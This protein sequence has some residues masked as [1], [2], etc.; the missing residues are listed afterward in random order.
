MSD[1]DGMMR[2]V[3][4]A[5]GIVVLLSTM[6]GSSVLVDNRYAKAVDVQN[7][8]ENLYARTLK[9]RI[10]ELQLKPA[11]QFTAADKALLEHLKQ[12]L[13]EANQP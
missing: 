2:H 11:D 12:E 8:L 4:L 5:A 1:N 3:E 6:I 7:Q 9:L 10:L 13:Q